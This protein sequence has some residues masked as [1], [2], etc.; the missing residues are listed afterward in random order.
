MDMVDSEVMTFQKIRTQKLSSRINTLSGILQRNT[1]ITANSSKPP[2]LLVVDSNTIYD[3]QLTIIL[4]I[5][6][7][8]TVPYPLVIVASTFSK[9]LSLNLRL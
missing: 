2:Q 6:T 7:K 4:R 3:S 1:S 5:A 8:I 9:I